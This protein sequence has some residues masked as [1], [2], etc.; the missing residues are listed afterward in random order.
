LIPTHPTP[1]QLSDFLLGAL[2][3]T[4][5]AAVADHLEGCAAC[6]ET[7]AE[8]ESV[9][10]SLLVG[11][12]QTPPDDI[13][14]VG[15]RAIER[16]GAASP[17]EGRE[18]SAVLA[19]STGEPPSR[20]EFV[21]RLRAAGVVD[22]D[23][24]ARFEPDGAARESAADGAEMARRLV[25]SGELTPF[26]A[27][28]LLRD[29]NCRLRFGEYVVVDRLGAGGM[30]E[31]YR[32]RHLRMDRVVA[33]KIPAEKSLRSPDAVKRFE[34]EVKAAARL[35]HPNIVTAYDAGTQD[36]AP[37]LVMEYVDGEDLSTRVR[38]RGP[39]SVGQAVDVV[40]QAAC[41]L[42]FAHARGIVHRDIKPA[43]L[44]LDSAGTV[45]ILDMG[46]ARLELPSGGGGEHGDGLTEIGQVM[47]TADYMAP[48]QTE[49]TSRADAKADV[50]SLGCTL[51]RLLTG[52]TPYRGATPMAKYLEH[53]ERTIPSLRAAR[54]EVPAELDDLFRR[55]LAK[56]PD[57]RP[58]AAEAVAE[59][60]SIERGSPTA[61]YV[62]VESTES[63]IADRS[64][65]DRNAPGRG[66]AESGV[67]V[68]KVAAGSK[69]VR[70]LGIAIL[71]GMA[72]WLGGA[73][74][75]R[76]GRPIGDS[77]DESVA[78]SSRRPFVP[79]HPGD[80]AR[81]QAAGA[82]LTLRTAA[83][84]EYVVRF[85]QAA[86]T[87]PVTIVGVD[88][89][90][91]GR[92][93]DDE[94]LNLIS[95]QTELESLVA[96]F[97]PPGAPATA[98]GLQ[99]LDSLTKLRRLSLGRIG[100]AGWDLAVLDSLSNLQTLELATLSLSQWEPRV[101]R[102]PALEAL[103]LYN[104]DGVRLELLGTP[105]RLT[106]LRFHGHTAG[107]AGRDAAATLFARQVPW[108]RIEVDGRVI[109]PS[110]PAPT[111]ETRR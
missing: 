107:A 88:L 65:S 32:A 51:Y 43:N 73:I 61:T 90:R 59:L 52:E 25:E 34:R 104:V 22:G 36:G 16:I 98:A 6:R 97:E 2:P 9:S 56:R 77:A 35:V 38:R 74:A 11:L 50:Y 72:A 17:G 47:G 87:D 49:D 26:Q 53:R 15:R 8:Q 79:S 30:G 57:D 45:K 111:A 100:P 68:A 62:T 71:A 24:L 21:A 42:A 3:D 102:L 33:L 89:G 39:A 109:E 7:I 96:D 66:V 29:G 14:E 54:P 27:E 85:D 48:E 18:E 84:R 40:R 95:G 31:V 93:C 83:D 103:R 67:A 86:P 63:S 70:L 5:V 78:Q 91:D 46:L 105:P 12:R 81:L 23:R 37:Y 13:D 28:T 110:A 94:L 60:E 108:C 20:E 10:D 106:E 1:E 55:M 82:S 4:A 64:A 75:A 69:V 58:T 44:L 41:G 101:A 99:Q 92:T 76:F 80:I 19:E